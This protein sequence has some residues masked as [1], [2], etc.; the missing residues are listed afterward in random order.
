[1]DNE[2]LTSMIYWVLFVKFKEI[3]R[4]LL[5]SLLLALN[6]KFYRDFMY[7]LNRYLLNVWYHHKHFLLDLGEDLNWD[8]FD[9]NNLGEYLDWYLFD[10]RNLDI[11]WFLK[12]LIYY[13]LYLFYNY[14]LNLLLN[15]LLNLLLLLDYFLVL[16]YH[17][18]WYLHDLLYL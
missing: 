15:Y 12:S 13:L 7:K 4:N 3:D 5:F 14:L 9:Y 16:N 2:L 10:N 11:N 6:S 8:L 18:N 17:L 1:V